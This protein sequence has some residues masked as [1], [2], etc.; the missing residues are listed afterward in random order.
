MTSPSRVE[1][2]MNAPSLLHVNPQLH[3]ISLLLERRL[4]PRDPYQRPLLPGRYAAITSFP[5][6]RNPFPHASGD[7]AIF[8]DM[9]TRLL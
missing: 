5:L 4:H 7:P 8:P 9:P 3:T 6:H 2:H 1:I